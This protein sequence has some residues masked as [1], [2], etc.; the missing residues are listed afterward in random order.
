[1]GGING[2]SSIASSYFTPSANGG[3]SAA[4]I[5]AQRRQ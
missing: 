3:L 5:D 1:M 2:L 4:Q